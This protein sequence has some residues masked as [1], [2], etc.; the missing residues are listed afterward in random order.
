[1]ILY[2]L[3]GITFG[4][5]AAAQPGVFQTYLISQTLNN[6]WRRT[7]PLTFAPLLSDI[8]IILVVLV[9]LNQL[10]SWLE[11]SL[12]IAG[13]FFLLYLA[14][15]IWKKWQTT[16]TGDIPVTQSVQINLLQAALVNLLNP[17]P[18]L[19]WSL[20]MGPLLL[21][22]WQASPI[23]GLALVTGFYTTMIVCSMAIVLIFAMTINLG[24]RVKQILPLAS[25]LALI[26]LGIYQLWMGIIV[27]G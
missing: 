19:G 25:S 4:F 20:I 6:G 17:A 13:G 22:G 12:R 24:P 18:Y 23:H 2:L 11:Q 21:K 9:I 15:G 27:G 14:Y 16:K 5:A 3:Q 1:L 26:V 7:L 8:P 10:P